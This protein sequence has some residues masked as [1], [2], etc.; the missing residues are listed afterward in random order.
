[1][2]VQVALAKCVVIVAAPKSVKKLNLEDDLRTEYDLK[3]LKVRKFEPERK[4]FGGTTVCLDADV[5]EMFPSAEAVN[6]VLRF[7]I[8]VTPIQKA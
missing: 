7:L 3:S 6:E 5:P 8:G 2:V 1:M 4:S